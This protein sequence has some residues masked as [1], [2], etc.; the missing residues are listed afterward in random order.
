M[1]AQLELQ[2]ETIAR[3]L[4]TQLDSDIDRTVKAK[5][6]FLEWRTSFEK[7]RK[8]IFRNQFSVLGYAVG[9]ALAQ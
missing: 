1:L 7:Q 6:K 9:I 5:G 4:S 3:L 2:A 8:S